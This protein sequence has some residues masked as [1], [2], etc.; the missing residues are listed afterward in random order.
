[1]ASDSPISAFVPRERFLGVEAP[2]RGVGV[3]GQ[4]EQEYRDE[5]PRH[6][7]H[8][9]DLPRRPEGVGATPVEPPAVLRR[10]RLRQHQGPVREVEHGEPGGDEERGPGAELG[11]EPADQR[12]GDEADSEAG[13][14]ETE[15]LR[16]PFRRTDVGH[17]GVGG[18]VGRAGDAGERAAGE[19][20]PQRGREAHDQVVHRQGEQRDQQHRAPA[21][22]IRQA[23]EGRSDGELHQR[24]D[25]AQVA[26]PERG[27][28]ER[29]IG[30][31]ADQI[32]HDRDDDPDAHGVDE[33][34]R[35]DERRGPRARRPTQ[36]HQLAPAIPSVP[37]DT[38]LSSRRYPRAQHDTPM[39]IARDERV[40]AE[41]RPADSVPRTPPPRSR[42]EPCVA[43]RRRLRPRHAPE[44]SFHA[45]PRP[46]SGVIDH[47][48]TGRLR[49]STRRS[50]TRRRRCRPRNAFP[51]RYARP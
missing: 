17:E 44:Q 32:G 3:V 40:G 18:G 26:A 35:E 25:E 41:V 34:R 13:P 16:P 11:G 48:R 14:D 36:R 29:Q 2:Y 50:G 42:C 51:P 12:P 45:A 4:V 49:D 33:H 7:R 43:S 20:Q 47:R 19:Q 21:V 38:S 5:E 22:A 9:C 15:V 28:P 23:A 10:Q 37:D 39:R 24:I 6:H 8:R 30:Q 46:R 27:G 1:M 31:L